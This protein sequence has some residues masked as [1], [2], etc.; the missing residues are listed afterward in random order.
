[1]NELVED[2]VRIFGSL[3]ADAEEA[4]ARAIMDYSAGEHQ[5]EA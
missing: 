4:A 5:A 2:A 3:P 1:M